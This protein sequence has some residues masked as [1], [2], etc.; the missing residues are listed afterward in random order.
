MASL[1]EYID[2]LPAEETF[3]ISESTSPDFVPTALAL[4]LDKASNAPVIILDRPIGSE[5]PIVAN[6]FASRSR[7]ARLIGANAETFNF[8]WGRILNQPL[9][10]RLVPTGPIKEQVWVGDD[11]DC[12][13]LPICRHFGND[14]GRYVNAGILVCKDPDTGTRNLSMQR[15]LLKGPRRFTSNLGSRGDI[16]EHLG[17]VAS[18]GRNLEVAVVIGAHPAVYLAASAKVA[19]DVDEYDIAGRLLGSPVDLVKCETIDVEVPADAEIVLEGELLGNEQDDEGPVAE[20]TGYSS[21]RSTRNVF[22]VKAMTARAKPLYLDI[23]SGNAAEHLLLASIARQ[24]RVFARLKEMIP[25]IKALNYPSSGTLY[26]AFLSMKKLA[27]GEARRALTLLF[28]LDPYAKLAVVVD[29]DVDVF[30]ESQVMWAIATRFQADTDMFVVPKVFCNMID[31]SSIDGMSAKLGIDAT[32]PP[33]WKSVRA[34]IPD[35]TIAAA[36]NLIGKHLVGE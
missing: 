11:A 5:M 2:G 34:T 29:D 31:P 14:A 30:D 13:S 35:G 18:R 36:R 3:R 16:W 25:G 9:P 28:G 27:E 17:R 7:V 24:A 26:H 4:E 6:L 20:Y 21:M 8:E 12:T 19:Q 1:G 10:P 23:I 22:I 15:L 32:V 33:G